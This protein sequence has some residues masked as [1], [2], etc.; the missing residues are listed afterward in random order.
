MSML[1]AMLPT[2]RSMFCQTRGKTLMEMKVG[3]SVGASLL[4]PAYQYASAAIAVGNMIGQG[5][6]Y[7]ESSASR[8]DGW[9]GFKHRHSQEGVYLGLMTTHHCQH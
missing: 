2:P 3:G 1:C 4:L 9:H 8:M 7:L 6:R 5:T